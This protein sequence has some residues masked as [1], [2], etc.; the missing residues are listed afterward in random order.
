MKTIKQFLSAA[1]LLVLILIPCQVC[2]ENITLGEGKQ[3][4]LDFLKER[5]STRS[6]SNVIE[7]LYHVSLPQDLKLANGDAP[8]YI[9]NSEGAFVIVSSE[10]N[11]SKVLAYSNEGSFDMN[12]IAPVAKYFLNFYKSQI[13][14]VKVETVHRT[15]S[16][17]A[18]TF[19]STK[20]LETAKFGQ[21]GN[22]WWNACPQQN[23]AFCYAGCGPA[24]M[25][26]VMKYHNWPKSGV[27][28]NSVVFNGSRYSVDFSAQNYSWEIIPTQS[29]YETYWSDNAKNEVAKILY[30]CGVASNS[31]YSVT[32]TSTNIID[33]GETLVEHFKYNVPLNSMGIEMYAEIRSLYDDASWERL[34]KKE[35]DNDRPCIL[36]GSS[37]SSAHIFVCDGYDN[38]GMF[39]FN[40]GW[41]GSCN[42]FYSME[43]VS[44]SY[45]VEWAVVGITPDG[46]PEDEDDN[47]NDEPNSGSAHEYVDLGLSVMW[48]T[49][50]V[51]AASPEDF[52]DYFAWG[53]TTP[54][55]NYSW[56]TYKHC[57]ATS[58]SITKYNSS[59]A[60]LKPEDDAATANWGED[61]RMP[62]INEMNE[63]RSMCTWTFTTRG[64]VKGYDVKGPNGNHI[65]LP[66]AGM[67]H[68]TW[69]SNFDQGRYWTSSVSSSDV[70]YASYLLFEATSYLWYM[71]DRAY[72][73]S[74]RPVY[75]GEI[76][77]PGIED[78]DNSI[79]DGHEYVD[80]G[81]PSKK[82]W[83]TCNYGASAPEKYGT[84]LDWCNVDEV[85]NKWGSKWETPSYAEVRELMTVCEWTED[86]KNGVNGFTVTGPNGNTL[87]LPSAGWSLMG[88]TDQVGRF[89][90]YW[91]STYASDG[92][93]YAMYANGTTLQYNTS[94]NSDLAQLPVRP[95][96][97][98]TSDYVGIGDIEESAVA[99]SGGNG[100][101]TI[102]GS[103]RNDII[104]IYT[105]NGVLVARLIAESDNVQIPVAEGQ[106]YIVQT[107]GQV[108][109]IQ[110]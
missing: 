16:T 10:S 56:E 24:A 90:C 73:H 47:G 55:S 64:G 83:A 76:K 13:E 34:L 25:A 109:K 80:L 86:T 31:E 107:A 14:E 82:L 53:E 69:H 93:A 26:I 44:G 15:A 100:I 20:V 39:H 60:V 51:G 65:F 87:F 105:I 91:T 30:H 63:L 32:G 77:D 95:I 96:A 33:I 8:F 54:K 48:A 89:A 71:V 101:I 67:K 19:S 92:F 18:S 43:S 68:Y 59:Y 66:M 98:V 85:T 104:S 49:M 17:S 5:N 9:F 97:T 38:S 75:Q 102:N 27:G 81:L 103:V 50:N 11:Y 2:A 46:D 45:A 78:E 110:M 4:A 28:S 6:M 62:N 35:I 12:N 61:W 52:G 88:Y 106:L 37:E 22:F 41:S 72:G 40:L 84:Y 3:I 94:Y 42:G 70:S 21:N 99:V 108:V 23:G 57:N 7:E 58:G 36:L 1:I 29:P 74:V 79:L